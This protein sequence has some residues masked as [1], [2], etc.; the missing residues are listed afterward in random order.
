MIDKNEKEYQVKEGRGMTE[1][2]K[3]IE[4]LSFE[5]IGLRMFSEGKEFKLEPEKKK[6]SLD[7]SYVWTQQTKCPHCNKNISVWKWIYRWKAIK[8]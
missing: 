5:R 1:K 4:K 7:G 2:D 6:D 3:L 8:F